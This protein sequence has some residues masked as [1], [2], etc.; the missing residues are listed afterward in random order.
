MKTSLTLVRRSR[1]T[2]DAISFLFKSTKLKSWLPGQYLRWTLAHPN[3]DGRGA[4]REFTISSAPFEGCIRLTTRF[5]VKKGS[6]FKKALLGMAIGGTIGAEGPS[7]DFVAK[8]TARRLVF[9]AGGVGVTPY[10]AMLL[11]LDRAGD[12]LNVDLLYADH[13]GEFPFLKKFRKLADKHPAFRLH[14][15]SGSRRLDSRAIAAAVGSGGRP[16]F[17]VSGPEPMVGSFEKRLKRMGVPKP[18]IKTDYFP[19]YSWP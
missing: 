15:F 19:G 7:G 5:C 9:I 6:S 17:Y 3:P 8:S 14:L 4:A 13:G 1:E 18:R 16:V 11:A 12:P 10:R 2:P